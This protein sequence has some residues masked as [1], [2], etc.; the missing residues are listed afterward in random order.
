MSIYGLYPFN[1]LSKMSIIHKFLLITLLALVI[2]SGILFSL[3]KSLKEEKERYQSNTNALL[4]EV[5]R[6]KIDSTTNAVD[7]KALKLTI[8]EFKQYRSKDLEQIKKLKIRIKDI[9]AVSKHKLEIN[10]TINAAVK[11]TMILR[12]T[13]LMKLQYVQMTTPHLEINGIIE[14]NRLQ[15]RIHLP[16][17]LHQI[18]WVEYKHRFLWFKWGTKTVHQTIT[19][20][21]PH[22]KINYSELIQIRN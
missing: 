16:V 20:D 22:V 11:D 9:Q 1:P 8:D 4:S 15:G 3:V 5:N 13:I 19:T 14:H 12:D 10:A 18:M 21:N 6:L 17:N 2:I 7:V